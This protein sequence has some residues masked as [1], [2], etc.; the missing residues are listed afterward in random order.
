MGRARSECAR[1]RGSSKDELRDWN[2]HELGFRFR[3]R[4]QMNTSHG[5][6]GASPLR[7]R[8]LVI[9]WAFPV[10]RRLFY[11]C[12][13]VLVLATLLH[14]YIPTWAFMLVLTP[15]A[16][17]G[18]AV[19]GLWRRAAVRRL[20]EKR[21]PF[22]HVCGYVLSEATEATRCSECGTQYDASIEAAIRAWWNC[23]DQGGGRNGRG[24]K[25][26]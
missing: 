10:H 19:V 9:P 5:N 3:E 16:G 8:D 18:A 26:E 21:G 12:L 25:R 1:S 2:S 20:L 6:R 14:S 4:F 22:C 13:A 23:R 7:L 24:Q 11:A 15:V 17:I